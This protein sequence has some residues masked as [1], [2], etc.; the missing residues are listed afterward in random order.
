MKSLKW[1]NWRKK[2]DGNIINRIG[3]PIGAYFGYKAIGIYR[4]EADLQ[5]TNSKGEVIKQKRCGSQIGRYHVRR[6]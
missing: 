4:T 2:I 3:N 5:R 6:P 1:V